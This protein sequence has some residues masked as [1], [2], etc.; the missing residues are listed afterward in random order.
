MT[1]RCLCVSHAGIFWLT[2]SPWACCWASPVVASSNGL[3]L[4]PSLPWILDI[5]YHTLPCQCCRL[6]LKHM[7]FCACSQTKAAASR[8]AVTDCCW[9]MRNTEN[10]DGNI[11]VKY[12]TKTKCKKGLRLKISWNWT[13]YR[14]SGPVQKYMV[15]LWEERADR[16]LLV[17]GCLGG[18]NCGHSVWFPVIYKNNS[19][20]ELPDYQENVNIC[21]LQRRTIS[22]DKISTSLWN[23]ESVWS[24]WPIFPSVV[25]WCVY[26]CEK[27]KGRSGSESQSVYISQSSYQKRQ[28][29]VNLVSPWPWTCVGQPC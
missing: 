4:T 3:N 8:E 9:G 20:V 15:L 24:H 18:C 11:P 2:L 1:T 6:L 19:S 10:K 12:T 21:C 22:L 16:L 27:D 5:Y 26:F 25:V 7:C 17:A 29:K 13:K 28:L 23:V 14:T